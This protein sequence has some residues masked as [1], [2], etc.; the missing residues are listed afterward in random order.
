MRIIAKMCKKKYK[1]RGYRVWSDSLSLPLF[2]SLSLAH[3]AC[4]PLSIPNVFVALAASHTQGAMLC[5]NM[6]LSSLRTSS[7]F[8]HFPPL[9]EFCVA[10]L[11]SIADPLARPLMVDSC[12]VCVTMRNPF[13]VIIP[14]LPL[15]YL[16]LLPLH[17]SHPF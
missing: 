6:Q 7:P 10:G 1:P 9:D 3:R 15:P 4:Y 12:F 2:P 8:S 11:V 13:T 17:P 5:P 16:L 14:P